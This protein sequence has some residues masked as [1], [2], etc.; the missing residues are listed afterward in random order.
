MDMV[1][2]VILIFLAVSGKRLQK[3]KKKGNALKSTDAGKGE[4]VLNKNY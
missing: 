4:A 2:S 1:T 3:K